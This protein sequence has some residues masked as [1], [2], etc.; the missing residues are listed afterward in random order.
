MAGGRFKGR[1][2]DPMLLER[3]ERLPEGADW[4]YEIKLDG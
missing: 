2:I 3:K 4:F 1:F